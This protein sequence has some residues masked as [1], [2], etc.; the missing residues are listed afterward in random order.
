MRSGHYLLGRPQFGARAISSGRHGRFAVH[1]TIAISVAVMLLGPL[2]TSDAQQPAADRPPAAVVVFRGGGWGHGVG[3]SQF[4]AYGRAVAGATAEQILRAYYQDT[5]VGRA[6]SPIGELRVSLG[7]SSTIVL[8][9]TGPVIM[10]IDGAPAAVIPA[11]VSVTAHVPANTPQP[12]VEVIVPEVCEPGQC[13]G[14]SI[15]LALAPGQP[16]GVSTTG[17]RYDEGVLSLSPDG[18][19]VHTIVGSLTF[20][21]YLYGLA[22]MPSSWPEAALDAQAI[23]A[24]SYAYQRATTARA[25]G[26]AFDL[27]ATIDDQVYVG[28]DKALAPGGERWVAAVDRTSNQFVTDDERQPVLAMYSSSNGGWSESSEY[29]FG[30][31][32]PH[33][34]AHLDP[35]D[36]YA[37]PNALWISGLSGAE[38]GRWLQPATGAIG[39]L[40][41]ISVVGPTGASGRVDQAVVRVIGTGGE[42]EI[43]GSTLRQLVNAGAGANTLRSSRFTIEVIPVPDLGDLGAADDPTPVDPALVDPADIPVSEP[44]FDPVA[45]ALA[46]RPVTRPDDPGAP[47]GAIAVV[48]GELGTMVTGWAVDADAAEP[49]TPLEPGTEPAPLA[50][51]ITIDGKPVATVNANQPTSYGPVT[52]GAVGFGAPIV[53]AEG[54]HAVCAEVPD[55]P[56]PTLLDPRP[57]ERHVVIGCALVEVP[58]VDE[59]PAGQL[60]RS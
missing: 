44:D 45:L 52:T 16:V 5:T 59:L 2:A 3:M 50:V 28:I 54:L 38:V 21:Q 53:A 32:R 13:V 42:A 11:G 12:V 46:V 34:A 33:L 55:T 24:R 39:E 23:A 30:G 51:R 49:Q 29:V 20:D 58:P 31:V 41:N 4:G 40:V 18:G 43:S 7:V 14:A 56:R 60:D 36:A 9:T 47:H 37:N 27:V 35:W 10:A 19:G 22:E 17:R 57:V 1:A 8:D 15:E 6:A 25:R 48:G 26:D